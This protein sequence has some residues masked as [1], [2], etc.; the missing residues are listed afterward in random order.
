MAQNNY[1]DGWILATLAVMVPI[2]MMFAI[3]VPIYLGALVGLYFIYDHAIW[4]VWNNYDAV[5]YTYQQ[6]YDQFETYPALTFWNFLL[7]KFG[8]LMIGCVLTVVMVW[9]FIKYIRSVFSH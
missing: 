9:M 4:T 1:K 6:L 3:I 7:P 5:I 8:C 2:I